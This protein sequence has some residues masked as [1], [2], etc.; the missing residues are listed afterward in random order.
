DLP[1]GR[2]QLFA[3]RE[4]TAARAIRVN[5][6]GAGPFTPV[7]LVLEPAAIVTGRVIDRESSDGLAAA[8][9]LRPSGDDQ[10]PRYARSTPD[11]RFKIEGVPNGKWIADAYAPGYASPGGVEVDA[12]H[13][14]P[15]LALT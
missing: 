6:L 11:G 5:R 14:V 9:E 7:E 15:E 12:G 2:Y 3:W 13:G 1:E 4:S 8:I 10:A